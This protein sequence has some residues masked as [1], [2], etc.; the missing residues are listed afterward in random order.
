MVLYLKR[1]GEKNKYGMLVQNFNQRTNVA[2]G[3][4]LL[5]Y[6]QN[7]NQYNYYDNKRE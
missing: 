1:R 2:M 4:N 6:P 5:I 7:I 3:H